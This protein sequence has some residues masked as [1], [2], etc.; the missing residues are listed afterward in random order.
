MGKYLVGGDDGGG[1]EGEGRRYVRQ[2]SFSAPAAKRG[3]IRW[4]TLG[5]GR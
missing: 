2:A 3:W 4:S 1:G 5:K